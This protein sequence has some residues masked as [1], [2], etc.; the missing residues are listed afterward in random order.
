MHFISY[1]VWY[2]KHNSNSNEI[3]RNFTLLISVLADGSKKK[4]INQSPRF[5]SKLTVKKSNLRHLFSNFLSI[6]FGCSSSIVRVRL[7]S[8][9]GISPFCNAHLHNSRTVPEQSTYLTLKKACKAL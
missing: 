9:S 4:Y 3:N 7:Q 1:F 2:C 6:S 8:C 5:L